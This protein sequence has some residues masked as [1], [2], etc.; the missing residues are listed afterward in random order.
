MSPQLT[1]YLVSTTLGGLFIAA[2]LFLIALAVNG[3]RRDRDAFATVMFMLGIMVAVTGLA[4]I[5]GA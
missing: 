3:W 1:A 4:L 5:T 2:S